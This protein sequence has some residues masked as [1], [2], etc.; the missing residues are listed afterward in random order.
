MCKYKLMVGRACAHQA[1]LAPG[2]YLTEPS[3]F[4]LQPP[5][6]THHRHSSRENALSIARPSQS[7]PFPQTCRVKAELQPT[8]TPLQRSGFQRTWST[9]GDA[10]WADRGSLSHSPTMHGG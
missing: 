6:Q 4:P 10:A 2:P 3:S 1:R 5:T 9:I 8:H 7:L